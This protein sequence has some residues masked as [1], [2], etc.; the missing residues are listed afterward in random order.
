MAAPGT[1]VCLWYDVCRYTVLGEVHSWRI[2]HRQN[3]WGRQGGGQLACRRERRRR[4]A[5][6]PLA[7]PWCPH[8]SLEVHLRGF[9]Q[10]PE[11]QG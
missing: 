11:V 9:E 7:S 5:A 2:I 3:L 8:N 1:L 6:K 4:Q 10:P